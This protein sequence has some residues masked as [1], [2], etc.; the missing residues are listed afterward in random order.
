MSRH[1]R[2]PQRAIPAYERVLA[3]PGLVTVVGPDVIDDNEHMAYS[4]YFDISM[5]SQTDLLL[6]EFGLA[7]Q[8][9]RHKRA[10]FIREQHLR[11]LSEAVLGDELSA[12]P[13]VEAYDVGSVTVVVWLANRTRQCIAFQVETIY[14]NMDLRA[15]RRVDF[16]PEVQANIA[17]VAARHRALLV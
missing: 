11:Y 12:H 9:R 16:A 14:V 8:R 17:T 15:R 6:R 5:P 2:P 10:T 13:V 1:D 4:G 3:V 7:E